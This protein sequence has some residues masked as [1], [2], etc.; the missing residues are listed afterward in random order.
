MHTAYHL[1]LGGPLPEDT[2]YP[3][4]TLLKLEGPGIVGYE[5]T[6]ETRESP[7]LPDTKIRIW[8]YRG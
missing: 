2:A 5:W 1:F 7:S 6:W 4:E 3:T 8:R